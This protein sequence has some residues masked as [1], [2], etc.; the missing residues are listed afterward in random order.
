[1]TENTIISRQFSDS[2][3]SP[4]EV[5]QILLIN[6][7]SAVDRRE[8]VTNLANTLHISGMEYVAGIDREKLTQ[9]E[10][11]EILTRARSSEN[12][13]NGARV[14]I[15]GPG[16][17]YQHILLPPDKEFPKDF[18]D[19]IVGRYACA[20]SHVKAMKK[21]LENWEKAPAED[22]NKW[23]I[24]LEDDVLLSKQD[25]KKINSVLA[26]APETAG[27]ILLGGEQGVFRLGG[28]YS[29]NAMLPVAVE[30]EGKKN[31]DLAKPT[32]SFGATATAYRP[33]MLRA[34]LTV[35]EK[36]L[37]MTREE[38][39]RQTNDRVNVVIQNYL[40]GFSTLPE[41]KQDRILRATFDEATSDM[42]QKEF[43]ALNPSLIK[44][45]I[46]PS[47]VGNPEQSDKYRYR[48]AYRTFSPET[49]VKVYELFEATK[50]PH[51]RVQCSSVLER[52]R[53]GNARL[54]ESQLVEKLEK[55]Q[56]DDKSFTSRL[57]PRNATAASEIMR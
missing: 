49:A 32:G 45:D 42:K 43:F 37:A 36:N 47:T 52:E 25:K 2:Y 4:N 11:K 56:K 19:Y 15:V 33:D 8:R 21:A 23:I 7:E 16:T 30:T 46:G 53:V 10:R 38:G 14:N 29:L 27:A 44:E 28:L 9:K 55:I 54:T 50:N 5:G 24:I 39:G 3:F 6:T 1:M 13:V 35:Q 26:N 12:V 40:A 57:G 51:L 31:P 48:T 22:K 34:M 20:A 18:E 41:A 17:N